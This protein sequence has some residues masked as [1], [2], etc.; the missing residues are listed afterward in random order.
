MGLEDIR[1]W[2]EDLELRQKLEEN[3]S[4]VLVGLILVIVFSL[5]AVLCQLT[6]GGGGSYTA[7][8]ELVYFDLG[9][10]TVRLIEHE[11]PAIPASPL[12]GTDNVFLAT[13]FSCEECEKGKIKDGMTVEDLK[14]NGMFIGWL[15]RIPE[16]V[17]DELMLYGEGYEYRTVDN[18]RWYKLEEAG[19]QK[20]M[21]APYEKCPTVQVCLP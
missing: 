14:A 17:D 10:Q 18:D 5:G 19:S 20:I 1:Y 8:V 21:Q 13:V 12:K 2:F 9:A 6:G 4:I 11:Y 16:D 3:Q 15:E 7:E